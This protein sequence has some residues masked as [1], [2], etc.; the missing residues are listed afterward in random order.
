VLAAE[1]PELAARLLLLSYPLHPPG[2]PAQMRTT[3][4]PS[5]RMPALF[6]HGMRD[7]FG[8]ADEMT[9]ALGLIPAKTRLVMVSRAGHDLARGKF[10]LTANLVEPLR[11]LLG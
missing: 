11:S 3:H 9:A 10:D 2:K 4:F 7:D 5:L 1:E 8:T 6:V